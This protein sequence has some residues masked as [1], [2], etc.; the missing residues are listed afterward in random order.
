MAQAK[1]DSMISSK[2]KADPSFAEF[3]IIISLMMS[4]T[5]LSID[6]MLPALPHIGSD[7]NVQNANDRQLVVSLLFLGMAV[8]QM[9]FGPLSDK[10][11]RKPAIYWGYALFIAGSLLSLFALSFS[12]LLFGRLLQGTGASAPRAV[13]VALVRDR[14]EGRAM[15]RVM[16]FVMTVFVLV[17]MLA[18]TFGQTLLL[19]SGWRSIFGSFVLIAV[20]AV[21]WFALRVPET[22]ARE[23]RAPF[24]LRRILAAIREMV[25]IRLA[26]GYTVA[27]GFISGAFLG[28]L[29]SAQQIF[30]ELYA[31]EELFPLYFAVVAL[32][33]GLASLLNARL[34]MRFGMSLLVRWSLPAVLG[35]SIA[36][37]GIALL[38]AG[39]PPLWFLMAYLMTTF[40]CIGILFGNM[41][42][43][44]MNPLGHIAGIGAAVMGSLSTLISV[45]IGII[46][47]QSYNDTI[48]PLVAGMVIL[49]GISIVVVRWAEGARS[50]L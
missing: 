33:L 5:A 21:L 19:F 26:L 37:L 31:L 40:F 13:T 32:S 6:A 43:L 47:G 50:P 4:L 12:M 41:N 48:L 28:Y 8:G 35:L 16:S 14:Y 42:A 45:P 34:V 27:A 38:T 11:G 10:T 18:P 15:A 24:S 44:A 7:L 29:N 46:I 3:V 36:A 25:S 9:F 1:S 49:A 2:S 30:Q 23:S 22:L 20:I 39:Q 17:P